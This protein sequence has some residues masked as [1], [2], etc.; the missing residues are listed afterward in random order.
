MNKVAVMH[1]SANYGPSGGLSDRSGLH[2][3]FGQGSLGGVEQ[4][5]AG[6]VT[7][8]ASVRLYSNVGNYTGTAISNASGLRV[9]DHKRMRPLS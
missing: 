8:V 5:F 3:D 4:T 7:G 2:T 6:E 1:L 9:G